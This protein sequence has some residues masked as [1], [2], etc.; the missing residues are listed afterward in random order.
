MSILAKL[1][2]MFRGHTHT[3]GETCEETV[4]LS[5]L[6]WT[7]SSVIR[8]Q[9]C[10]GCPKIMRINDDGTYIIGT[11]VGSPAMLILER[12]EVRRNAEIKG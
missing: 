11:P 6:T 9:R 8:F 4:Y 12:G 1:G 7:E 5:S 2:S 10:D 3:W